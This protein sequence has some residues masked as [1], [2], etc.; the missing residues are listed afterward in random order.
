MK[1]K[2]KN[3]NF[4]IFLFCSLILSI[5]TLTLAKDPHQ[6]SI[7]KRFCG[8]SLIYDLN[9][10]V[11]FHAAECQ[12][13][14]MPNPN[15][16]GYLGILSAQ[17]KGLVNWVTKQRKHIY[18][19]YMNETDSGHRLQSWYIEKIVIKGDEKVETRYW[20][21]Y[22]NRRIYYQVL[23]QNRIVYMDC[24][25]IPPGV[26]YDDIISAFYNFRAGSYGALKPAQNYVINSIPM[27]NVS[28]FNISTLGA[29]EEA[30]K[31]R[32]LGWN[33]RGNYLV[34]ALISKEVFGTK[35]GIVYGL[36]DKNSLPLSGVVE[37]VIGF[38]NVE[39]QLRQAFFNGKPTKF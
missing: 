9:F 37:D 30:R 33:D 10:M 29:A 15:G 27:Q 32:S 26:V 23:Q 20:L 36:L 21:D 35:A 28:T 8:E 4:L 13:M 25:H 31:R 24:D 11:I 38:G 34:R 5:P 22:K 39:G 19:A 12:V 2:M 14:L 1:L 18:R 16:R 7:G 6:Y 3:F 17:T